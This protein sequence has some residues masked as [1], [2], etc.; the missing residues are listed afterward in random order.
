MEIVRRA[1][2]SWESGDWQGPAELFDPDI[3]V[4]FST[5]AFPDPGAYRGGRVALAAW[6]RW[7]EAWED[8][9]LE[10]E[11]IIDLGSRVVS[12]NRLHGLGK[13]SGATVDAE[14]G[15]IFDC[16][17][18]RIVRMVFCDRAEALEAAGLG[19]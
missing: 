7:L 1:N 10:L 18:G 9:R 15:C 19:E 12:L 8:F 16:H 11:D 4:V 14:V 5:T 17:R 13:T 6:D 3:E 2:T